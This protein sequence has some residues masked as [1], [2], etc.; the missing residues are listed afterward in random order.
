MSPVHVY[1]TNSGN[2][3]QLMLINRFKACANCK[4][5]AAIQKRA[6]CLTSGAFKTTAAE[7]LNVELHLP[8]ISVHMNRL[9]KETACDYEQGRYSPSH[10]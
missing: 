10:D 6:A 1:Y 3:V 8:P 9:V 7:A 4:S 2:D 5:F